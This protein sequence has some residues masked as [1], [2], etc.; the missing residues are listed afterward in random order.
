MRQSLGVF[1]AQFWYLLGGQLTNRLAGFV[2]PF[3]TIYLA[4]DRGYSAEFTGAV[5]ALFGAG[6]LLAALVGGALT[7]R[8]GRRP[9]IFWSELLAG[10]CTVAFALAGGRIL[11]AASLFAIGL[12][13]TMPRPAMAAV[14]VDIV[15]QAEVMR[16]YSLSHWANNVGMAIAPV[17][18]IAFAAGGLRPLFIADAATTAAFGAIMYLTLPESRPIAAAGAVRP[19][20]GYAQVV[21]DARFMLFTVMVLAIAALLTQYYVTLPLAMHA[22]GLTKTAYATALVVNTV[23][24]TVL[25]VPLAQLT[26]SADPWLVLMAGALLVGVGFGANMWV[27]SALGYAATTAVWTAG[28]MLCVPAM[29]AITALLSPAHAR[30]RYQG[31]NSLAFTLAAVATP[32]AGASA[33]TAGGSRAVWLGSLVIGLAAAIGL[34]LLRPKK[35]PSEAAGSAAVSV[36]EAVGQ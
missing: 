12:F 10:A 20:A 30:G 19:K 11:I 1:P 7:D 23:M 27:Y 26:K 36:E 28:E 4:A 16:A 9:V 18:A 3:M 24:V 34:A 15:P 8:I 33:F 25:Q 6:C 29:A 2:T 22:V 35:R 5:V 32:V 21:R 13:S 14:I 31:V 17:L